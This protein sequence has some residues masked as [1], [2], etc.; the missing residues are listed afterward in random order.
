M[1]LP[2]PTSLP[3]FQRL[4][5]D[6]EACADYLE[7]IRWPDGFVCPRCGWTGEP[8]RF[9]DRPGVLR[10]RN[11]KRDTSLTAD[12]VMEGTRTPLSLWFWAAYLITAQVPG[13]SAL[14]LQRQLGISRYETAFQ[15]LHKLR[16][17][18]FR[19]DRDRIGTPYPVEMD[20]A[21]FGG[22][23]RGE[24]RG[25][26]H[27]TLVVGAVEIRSGKGEETRE[28]G[29]TRPRKGKT[30]AGRLR[31]R[32]IPD[33]GKATLEEFTTENIQPGTLAITDGWQGYDNL[34]KLGYQRHKAVLDGDPEQAEKWLP[35]IHIVFGNLKAWLTGI[36][37]GVSPQHLQ[38]YLN[39]FTFRFNRRF[40]PFTAFNSLLG[41]GVRVEAP[42]YAEL[43]SGEWR[44]PN[45]GAGG[46]ES[47]VAG[48]NRLM[49]GGR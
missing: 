36:H 42:T 44:H 21:Y 43:Y 15:M 24:G 39:E 10:C 1:P 26:H 20:E 17:G 37:H 18:M 45:P 6:E 35:M 41:I 2:F 16:A 12:T 29:A 30:Y 27:M 9:E 40:Y 38:A 46:G 5:P 23:T 3:D 31:L 4:F 48:L 8:Y 13:M 19:P 49:R 28:P 11:C 47:F 33:R 14:Q 25:V 7:D 32:V 22:R 34:G